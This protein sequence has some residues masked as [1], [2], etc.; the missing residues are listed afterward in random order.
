MA[1][2]PPKAP[3]MVQK[4]SSFGYQTMPMS[5]SQPPNWLDD[6]ID[7]A[8]TRR[9][10]HRRTSSDPITF[11]EM[12]EC[13]NSN[14]SDPMIPCSNS[15]NGFECLDD[16]QISSMFT[17]DVS[18]EF[19]P[20][21]STIIPC[22]QY[23]DNDETKT[24]SLQEQQM[25]NEPGE[26]EDA[27]CDYELDQ[28]ES[29]SA[30]QPPLSFSSDGGTI[31]DPK[32]V[33][34]ILANRQSAQR[35][36]VRKLH[37]ISELE[38]SVTNLQTE[39]STLSPRVAYLD[40]QRLILNVDNSSLKQRIA[41]LAQDKIF[42]DAHQ[43][44]LRKEIERLRRVYNDQQNM[45]KADNTTTGPT[46]SPSRPPQPPPASMDEARASNHHGSEN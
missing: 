30:K 28:R 12:N 16:E 4:W 15:N 2:L 19:Q 45:N 20:I 38:R 17:D 46:A 39:V 8:S 29:E 27:A 10:S 14:R 32:R 25:K 34:R 44:A 13:D 9:N 41:A 42:K 35:S 33:K 11:V 24:T 1:Q 18:T 6:F 43:E 26:V 3:A 23:S 7:F 36:R 5:A 40:H 22:D 31:V 37:Y 21:S